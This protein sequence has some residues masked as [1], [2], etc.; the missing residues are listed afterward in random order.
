M[1]RANI[2]V[3]VHAPSGRIYVQTGTEP[4]DQLRIQAIQACGQKELN[5]DRTKAHE[6]IA[7]KNFAGG[8]CDARYGKGNQYVTIGGYQTKG[9]VVTY[10]GFMQCGKNQQQTDEEFEKHCG[11]CTIWQHTNDPNNQ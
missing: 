10:N 7:V 9:P 5:G 6:C 1:M 2:G 4:A 8:A 3:A 11:G